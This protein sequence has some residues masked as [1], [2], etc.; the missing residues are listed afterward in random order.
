MARYPTDRRPVA[1]PG[2]CLGA[3]AR[4]RYVTGTG[5]LRSTT[6]VPELVP[7]TIISATHS[8]ITRN[9]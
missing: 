6:V 7:S 1:Q 8:R 4:Q 9:P 5:W 2:W 3:G